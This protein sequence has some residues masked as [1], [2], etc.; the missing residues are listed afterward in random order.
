[1]TTMQRHDLFERLDH[2]A[3]LAD[4]IIKTGR[5]LVPRYCDAETLDRLLNYADGSLHDHHDAHLTGQAP[6]WSRYDAEEE[7]RQLERDIE[8]F[9]RLERRL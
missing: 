8:A 4:R 6:P 2:A 1:M 7:Q 3:A 5:T 9:E